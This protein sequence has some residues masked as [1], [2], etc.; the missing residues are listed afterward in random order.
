MKN[1]Q[2]N[3]RKTLTTMIAI[4]KLS[5]RIYAFKLGQDLIQYKDKLFNKIDIIG[6]EIVGYCKYCDGQNDRSLSISQKGGNM[7]D[8]AASTIN[9]VYE[10]KENVCETNDNFDL[11]LYLTEHNFTA[12]EK[13]KEAN[14]KITAVQRIRF[15]RAIKRGLKTQVNVE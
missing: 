6:V 1:D 7:S 12:Y 10:P 14:E 3:T 15:V 13:I 9:F 5:M 4:T 2:D 8:V 11:K